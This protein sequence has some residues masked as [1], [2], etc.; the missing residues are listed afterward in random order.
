MDL[1]KIKKFLPTFVYLIFKKIYHI[2]RFFNF[3]RVNYTTSDKIS[4]GSSEAGDFLKAKIS[5]SKIFLEFGSGNTTIFA[6]KNNINCFSIE[7]DRNFYHYLKRKVNKNLFLYSLGL[8]EFYSYP[9]FRNIFLKKFYKKRAL[10]YSSKIFD[11][12]QSEKIFPDFILVDGRY[13]VLCMLTIFRF[14]KQNDLFNTCV[15][16]DDFKFRDYYNV[17]TQFFD[18]ELIGR[19]GVCFV[20]KKFF[21]DED[22]NKKIEYYSHDP[23]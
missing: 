4:F 6:K 15:V 9:L 7:S 19:L 8:V 21:I 14:L 12:L 20:K 18:V 13:R 16:L 17:I 22:L 10:L 2:L 3:I 11:K 1:K 5:S 23:R